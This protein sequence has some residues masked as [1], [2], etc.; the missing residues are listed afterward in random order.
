MVWCREDTL[1]C[2]IQPGVS[3]EQNAHIFGIVCCFE[4]EG[5]A[6]IIFILQQTVCYVEVVFSVH[7]FLLVFFDY[8][9]FRALK[10]IS[11]L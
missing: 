2:R 9:E 4:L 1:H 11:L 6:L 8:P 3:G 7:V 10:S 5:R